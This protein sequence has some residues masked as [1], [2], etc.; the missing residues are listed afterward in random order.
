MSKQ[1]VGVVSLVIHARGVEHALQGRPA[2][3]WGSP[4][5]PS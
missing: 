5:Y 1:D 2:R 4:M 3:H